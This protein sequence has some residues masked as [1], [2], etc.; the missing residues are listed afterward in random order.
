MAWKGL[1]LALVCVV[2]LRHASALDNGLALTPQ[3]GWNSWNRFGC[4]GLNEKV[5]RDTADLIVSMGFA[6]AGYEY[7]NLDDCWM[8][9]ER[10]AHGLLQPDPTTFPSGIKS[11]AD[12]VHSKGLRFGLY[13]SAGFKTCAGRPASLGKETEDATLWASWGVDFLKYDN[14]NTDGTPPQ[15][16]YPV[17]RDAL[18]ATGRPILFSMCEWGVNDVWTWGADVGNSWRTTGDIQDTWDSIMKILDANEPLWKAAGP[19]HWNDPD[20]LEVGN[21]LLSADEERSHFVMWIMLKAPL[22]LGCDLESLPKATV[23]LL[24][25]PELIA[26]TKDA[27]GVQGRRVASW[28]ATRASAPSQD[29]QHFG[30]YLGRGDDITSLNLTLDAAEEW[31][32]AHSDCA[33]FT[34]RGA[35]PKTGA[36]I[37]A[38]FKSQANPVASEDWQAFIR[39]TP[40]SA[41]P[42]EL[43]AAPLSTPQKGAVAA[44]ALNRDAQPRDITVDFA[45]LGFAEGAACDVRD[46]LER[47]HLGTFDGRFVAKAVPTHG[48]R[49]L[50]V[51]PHQ[52]RE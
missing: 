11:L 40:P 8:A 14:C 21:G 31:C 16:R 49:A 41:G 45:T 1:A 42:T 25:N 51:T 27:G 6:A 47:A 43:W 24:T 5:A 39:R 37:T 35:M 2:A 19:G 15:R 36:N 10:D 4:A 46:L 30:G 50:L 44:A 17:M 26:I 34:F 38:L 23:D 52:T 3:M 9:S 12:Y 48:V 28:N 18:N 20:M 33:G 32:T 13:S 29:F 7:L 22:L